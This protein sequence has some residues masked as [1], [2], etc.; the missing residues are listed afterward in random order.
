MALIGERYRLAA[1]CKALLN[2][3]HALRWRPLNHDA[4]SLVFVAYGPQGAL[5][6]ARVTGGAMP[7]AYHVHPEFGYFC[8]MP[9]RRRELRVALVSVLVGAIIGGSIATLRAG[10]DRKLDGA[11]PAAH[12]DVSN[13]ER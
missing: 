10:H 5:G 6:A 1:I 8:P 9:P 2:L 4:S 3:F 12:V 11:P 13:S 7:S